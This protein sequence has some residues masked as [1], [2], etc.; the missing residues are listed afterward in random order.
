MAGKEK[1]YEFGFDE[2]RAILKVRYWGFWDRA[3]G[4]KFIAEFEQQV[5][6]VSVLQKEWY[7]LANL[8][9][10]PPQSAELQR[11]LTEAM[12]FAKDHRLKKSARLVESTITQLQFERL[13]KD[14]HLQ[15]Y[16]FFTSEQEAIRWL[17]CE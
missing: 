5:Q 1:G 11:F 13:S 2:A 12:A 16:A 6:A 14:T 17:L 10:F 8:T 7:I 15:E 3:L 4:Q 9:Q